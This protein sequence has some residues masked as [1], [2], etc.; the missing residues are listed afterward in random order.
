[1]RPV[2]II[3]GYCGAAGH[4]RQFR[5]NLRGHEAAS[6]HPFVMQEYLPAYLSALLPCPVTH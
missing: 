2:S 6:R 4:L 3:V 1:L 5:G